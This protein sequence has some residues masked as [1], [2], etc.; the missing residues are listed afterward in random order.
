[1]KI[2]K[3]QAKIIELENACRDVIAKKSMKNARQVFTQI[4][5]HR[6]KDV[7]YKTE[8]RERTQKDCDKSYIS[9]LQEFIDAANAPELD[10]ISFSVEWKKSRTWGWCPRVYSRINGF[11][12]ESYASGCGYD[13]LSSAV[14]GSLH[15]ATWR[16]FAIENMKKLKNC[17]GFNVYCG[18]P[19]MDFAGCGMN[20]LEAALKVLGWKRHDWACRS[21]DKE[22]STIA[23]SYSKK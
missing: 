19:S 4:V 2:T 9:S 7:P 21:Y 14:C 5:A 12:G 13:K 6:K 20:T 22:G 3:L 15:S 8:Y 16:R 23:G 1:M 18:M 11:H 10:Y 17:Y